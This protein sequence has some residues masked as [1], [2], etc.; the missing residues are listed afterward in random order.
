ML[1]TNQIRYSVHGPAIH[2]SVS[3]EMIENLDLV[4]T[5]GD[6]IIASYHPINVSLSSSTRMASVA[7]C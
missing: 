1:S 5:T 7:F 6:N 2:R 4:S 3:G